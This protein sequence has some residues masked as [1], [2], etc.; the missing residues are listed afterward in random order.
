MYIGV[1][2]ERTDHLGPSHVDTC[3]HWKVAVIHSL[4]EKFEEANEEYQRLLQDREKKLGSSSADTIR[5]SRS[6]I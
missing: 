5:V 2:K 1:L 4:Q 3:E 6:A